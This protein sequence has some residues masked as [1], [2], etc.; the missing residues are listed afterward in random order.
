MADWARTETDRGA[1]FI[2]DKEIFRMQGRRSI[3][4]NREDVYHFYYLAPWLLGDWTEQVLRQYHWLGEP[5]DAKGLITD[6]NQLVA[7]DK[8]KGYEPVREWY[9]L[10]PVRAGKKHVGSLKE[11]PSEKWGQYW[12]VFR[13]PLRRRP[14]SDGE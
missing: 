5:M 13:I 14:T 6:V 8:G 2:T 12:R 3:F 7:G 1:V 9:V 10:L 4:V 11:I